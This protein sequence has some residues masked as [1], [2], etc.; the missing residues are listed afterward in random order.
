[1]R[2]GLSRAAEKRNSQIQPR[3]CRAVANGSTFQVVQCRRHRNP[4]DLEGSPRSSNHAV[5]PGRRRAIESISGTDL[6]HRE[7]KKSDSPKTCCG[8]R[9][10]NNATD[11]RFASDPLRHDALRRNSTSRARSGISVVCG[12]RGRSSRLQLF[13][14]RA[15]SGDRVRHRGV[16]SKSTRIE[17]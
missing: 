8:G 12:E 17:E 15:M 11:V 6:R 16:L 5:T 13:H 10:F 4:G 9:R 3:R 2:S 1:M 7:L 14:I